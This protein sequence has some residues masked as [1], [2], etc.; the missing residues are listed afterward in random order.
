M[1]IVTSICLL[2]ACFGFTRFTHYSV[3]VSPFFIVAFYIAALYLFAFAGLL[4]FGVY[5][6]LGVG[7][8]MM[9]FVAYDCLRRPARILSVY[10]TPGFGVWLSFA[11]LLGVVASTKI[12]MFGDDLMHWAPH[13]K[14]M[15]ANHGFMTANDYLFH[16]SYPPGARLF[17]YFYYTL[18]GFSEGRAL[19][20]QVLLSLS[21]I[22]LFAKGLSWSEWR[23][24]A[25]FVILGFLISLLYG[26]RVGPL[27][28]LLMDRPVGVFMGGALVF[29]C[30]SDRAPKDIVFLTPV[31]FAVMLFKLKFLPFVLLLLVIIFFDQALEVYNRY[32]QKKIIPTNYVVFVLFSLL[33]LLCSALAA[34]YSWVLYLTHIGVPLEWSA[35]ITFQQVMVSFSQVASA[36]D[37]LTIQHFKEYLWDQSGVIVALL[38]LS[39]LFPFALRSKVASVRWWTTAVWLPIGFLAYIFGLLLLYLYVFNAFHGVMLASILRYSGIYF[40]VWTFFVLA[41][42]RV[43]VGEARL[44]FMRVAE[45][46]LLISLVSLMFV[47]SIFTYSNKLAAE[48]DQRSRVQLREQL[49][50]ISDQVNALTPSDAKIFLVWQN[51]MGLQAVTLMYDLMPRMFNE[52]PVSFGAPYTEDRVWTHDIS[53]YE[54]VSRL[55]GYDYLLLGYTDKRFWD[56]YGILFDKPLRRLSPLVTYTQCE[57]DEFNDAIAEG[58]VVKEKRAYLFSIKRVNGEIYFT[59]I[60]SGEGG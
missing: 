56:R 42:F 8:V 41:L 19:L 50:K 39:Y 30:L 29:Y 10:L 22:C 32:Q 21:P 46:T 33:I 15:F 52:K 37:T 51:S 1:D 14:T 31:F 18:G 45:N 28:S 59:N 12:F 6:L 40:I 60:E 3:E 47:A 4:S 27:I 23:K 20:A 25:L 58:C 43:V 34:K 2:G 57:G 54:F 7:A 26:F 35:S 16:K 38:S 55:Q 24:A 9:P 48:S 36:R 44:S 17:H 11:V 49:A 53:P 13:T 5:C